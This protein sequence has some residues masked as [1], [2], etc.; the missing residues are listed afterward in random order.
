VLAE[1][2]RLHALLDGGLPEALPDVEYA[3]EPVLAGLVALR[4]HTAVTLS[5]APDL[6]LRGDPAV[7]AQI[8]TNLL[9]NCA[10]H[11]PGADVAVTARSGNGVVSIEVRDAGPGLPPE[12]ERTTS[13][14]PGSGLGLPISRRLAATQRGRLTLRTVMNPRGCS[15][16][17]SLPALSDDVLGLPVTDSSQP[18][19][20][21]RS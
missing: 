6:H 16:I 20:F 5:V 10:R 8:V 9:V 1:L 3:V 11:A 4:R 13:D 2:G 17:L 12:G 14:A 18:S 19:A 7:L 21:H 15:A